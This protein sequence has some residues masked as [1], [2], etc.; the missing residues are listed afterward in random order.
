MEHSRQDRVLSA[1]EEIF[2]DRAGRQVGDAVG[3]GSGD[4]HALAVVSPTSAGEVERLAEV[5]ARFSVPLVGLGAG[6]TVPGI[7]SPA[8]APSRARGR[9]YCWLSKPNRRARGDNGGEQTDL[10]RRS[11][12][13]TAAR[14]ATRGFVSAC[15]VP[16]V[17]VRL[18]SPQDGASVPRATLVCWPVLRALGTTVAMRGA[19]CAT[20][21]DVSRTWLRTSIDAGRGRMS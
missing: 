2:G 11:E 5:A 3:A 19:G 12:A 16:V 7:A 13:A 6:T 1:V 17:G 21:E 4:A 14:P 18:R 10:H 20:S 8:R 15:D 9:F